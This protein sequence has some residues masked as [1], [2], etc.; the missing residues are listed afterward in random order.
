M[1]KDYYQSL[2]VARNATKDEIKKAYRSLAHKYHPDKGGDEA[3]FKEINEAYQIL[4]DDTKRSQYD[5]FGRVFEGGGAQQGGFEWPGG[6]RFDF[7]GADGSSARGFNSE[8]DFSDVFEDFLGAGF[9]GG[10]RTKSRDRKGKDIKLDIRIPFEESILGAKRDVE[11]AKLARCARCS[12]S[13][14]EPDTKLT[15][16]PTCQG[17][18]NIQKT[19]RTFLGSFT[20]VST[21]PECNGAGKRPEKKCTRCHGRGV[22]QA[23]ERLEVFVPRGIRDGEILKISGKGEASLVGSLPGDLYIEIHVDPHPVFRRQGDDVIMQL[24]IK[25]SQAIAG[26]TVDV[27]TLD[28]TLRLKIPEGTQP[29]DILKIRGKGAYASSGYGRGDLLIEIKVEVP[30]KSGKRMKEIIEKLKD[31]GL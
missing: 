6:F 8:F 19:Q 29:G 18:G 27:E 13:G 11:I 21:C 5:Q 25:I 4:S 22:E 7:G 24:P 30:K 16:C 2:G 20:Q 17:K 28:G 23:T 14:G 26:D 15:N 3:R 10:N 12:G 9:G 1:S 31:E